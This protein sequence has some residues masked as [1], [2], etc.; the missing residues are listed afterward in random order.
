MPIKVKNTQANA[1][2]DQGGEGNLAGGGET[3]LKLMRMWAQNVLAHTP[4]S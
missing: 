2:F 3:G 1:V 4:A